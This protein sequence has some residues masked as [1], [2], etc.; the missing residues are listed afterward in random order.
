MRYE[1]LEEYQRKLREE[2]KPQLGVYGGEEPSGRVHRAAH[3]EVDDTLTWEF[4][5]WLRT[6]TKLPILIKV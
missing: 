6:V 3:D 1:N 2:G 5:S 4:I